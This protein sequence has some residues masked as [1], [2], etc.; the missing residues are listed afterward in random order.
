[1]GTWLADGCCIGSDRYDYV[2]VCQESLAYENMGQGTAN[3]SSGSRDNRSN[4]LLFDTQC[5][6]YVFVASHHGD[7]Y[8]SFAVFNLPVHDGVD[9]HS[10]DLSPTD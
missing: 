4:I 10:G 9:H 5:N 8:E 6:S 2:F 7:R 1:M 3:Y